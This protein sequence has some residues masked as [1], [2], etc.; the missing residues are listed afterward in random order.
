MYIYVRVCVCVYV[1]FQTVQMLQFTHITANKYCKDILEEAFSSIQPAV[2]FFLKDG[3]RDNNSTHEIHTTCD[4][5]NRVM[6]AAIIS[7]KLCVFYE[8]LLVKVF[9]FKDTI[10]FL[11]Y[12]TRQLLN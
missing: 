5:T 6:P 8:Y 3:S 2:A 4:M 9:D 10:Y 11:K 12:Y 1:H 7:W